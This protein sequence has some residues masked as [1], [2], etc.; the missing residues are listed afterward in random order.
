MTI[1][2]KIYEKLLQLII[3]M[4]KPRDKW[5]GELPFEEGEVKNE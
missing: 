4:Q 1:F 2:E 5:Q 3:D